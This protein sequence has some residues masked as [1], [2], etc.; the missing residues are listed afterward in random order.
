MKKKLV[1]VL[2]A[3]AS[4][5]VFY[6]STQ[7]TD[8]EKLREK[9]EAYLKKTPYTKTGKLNKKERKALGLP[10]NA[11]NEQMWHYTLDPS[12]GRPMPEKVAKIQNNLKLQ[13]KGLSAKTPG[14]ADNQWVDR[15]PNNLAG[16]TRGIMFDPNDSENKRVFA[17]G[18]S[19]GLWVNEDITN[20]NSSWTLVSG[21]G[22]N[23]SVTVITHDPN[24]TN[25]FYIGSG[26]SFTSGNAV[27][28]GIW[29]SLDGGVT[30]VNI[31]GGPTGGVGG[32][33]VDGVF[34][35][36]D[37]VARNVDGITELYAAIVTDS[38]RDASSP[39]QV[40]GRDTRG[41]YRSTD[42]GANWTRLEI[43]ETNNRFVNPCDIEIDISNNIWMATTSRV[44]GLVGGRIYKSS[45][46]IDF[47]LVNTLPSAARTEIE[48]SSLDVNKLWAVVNNASGGQ[49]ANIYGTTD[50]FENFTQLN[51]PN[52]VDEDI[53]ET[54][55]TRGQAF[56]DLPIEVDANDNLFVGGIDLFRSTDNGTTWTQL[57]K[58]SNNNQLR[59]LNVP[60]VH[61][62]HHAIVFRPGTTSEVVFGNDGGVY[63]TTNI[64]E[65][66]TT[67]D[68]GERNTNYNVT[69]FYYGA[70][71][72]SGDANG[73]D[74]AG[75]TQDNG[76]P[77]SFN[78]QP[79]AN[80]FPDPFGG[81]G[82]F[83]EIDEESGYMIQ[84][85]PFNTHNFI[86]YPI[87]DPDTFKQLTTRQDDDE[88]FLGNFINCAVLDKNLDIL[89]SNIS[90]N[91][92]YAIERITDFVNADGES[93]ILS[94]D[95][96]LDGNPSTM[97]I[98]PFTTT[99]SSIYL[100]LENSKLIRVNNANTESPAFTD[101]SGSNFVG[102]LSDIEFGTN[103]N[104]IFVTIHNYGVESIWYTNDGGASWRSLEGNLP[105]LPVKCI[106]QN[107][108]NPN[109]V[110]IGTELGI[111]KTDDFTETTPIWEQS[112]NGMSDVTV[113]DLDLRSSDN[114][115]LAATHGRGLFTSQ[116]TD[117]VA[118]VKEVINGESLF[119]IYPTVSKGNFTI[120]GKSSMKKSLV[121][122]FTI[123][124]K[125]VFNENVDF[126][127]NF[128]QKVR[129]NGSS[130]V[131]VVN[132]RTATGEQF[133]D[134]IIIR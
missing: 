38:Y 44:S 20:T 9:H 96:V 39:A 76:T 3:I 69:Q 52:D 109:E 50:G 45:N 68:I 13:H 132:I 32:S 7:K 15:G 74:I 89:Y 11:Y 5:S 91:S 47:T 80:S 2:I 4:F 134:K 90:L 125:R 23:I 124:G 51:E 105:D 8:S 46:G 1:L 6:F 42:N 127:E 108:L 22:A 118:A 93:E 70:I 102:S 81:D 115:I 100:G 111:W 62:D 94:D 77:I 116:F 18:V 113:V 123:N 53:P 65:D 24:N 98:S 64:L 35:V 88:E 131:Y 60:L 99:S 16:R 104:E 122:I 56:Y 63:Y 14:N 40:L 79:N 12:T 114:T 103:E 112:F 30:W 48:V 75:G 126:S 92:D 72:N 97:Q 73:D 55:Y 84:S 120:Y 17:G 21:I 49:V 121:Q 107:P 128:R 83:T 28:R 101:I 37:I 25:I 57:S 33:F 130:G 85:Y 31:F 133:S 87:L 34:Y 129:L 61:P 67:F 117:G 59:N 29:R 106:L 86:S 95:E 66:I 27:G 26:E 43:R 36:N 10:P 58:W 78:S 41:L 82:G 54:D 19:G 71:A 110:I 119:S